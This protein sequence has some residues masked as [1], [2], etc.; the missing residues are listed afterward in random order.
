MSNNACLSEQRSNL[1]LM[2]SGK[3]S[4]IFEGS[5]E[6]ACRTADSTDLLG[7]PAVCL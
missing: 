7:S 3:G 1:S 4:L 5:I 6:S 2:A